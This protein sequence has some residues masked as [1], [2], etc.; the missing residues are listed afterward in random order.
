MLKF[1]KNRFGLQPDLSQRLQ[2]RRQR[3]AG[4]AK[5]AAGQQCDG[6]YRQIKA[7]AGRQP[8]NQRQRAEAGKK[9]A[10]HQPQALA[11]ASAQK[12]A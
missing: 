3:R 8:V 2:R 4:Q 11:E 9:I 7:E 10:G 5:A 1:V 6:V 12:G